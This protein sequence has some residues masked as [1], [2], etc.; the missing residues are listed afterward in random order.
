MGTLQP[1]KRFTYKASGGADVARFV[2][3]AI[4][5]ETQRRPAAPAP[6]WPVVSLALSSSSNLFCESVKP[7][8]QAATPSEE[9]GQRLGRREVEVV[10]STLNAGLQCRQT[11]GPGC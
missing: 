2:D 1:C 7:R 6:S 8:S 11:L 10:S 9:F 3:D 4:T 5:T